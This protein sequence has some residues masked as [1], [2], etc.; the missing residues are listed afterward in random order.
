M[1]AENRANFR[2]LVRP[3]PSTAERNPALNPG[4]LS[5]NE[6]PAFKQLSRL[7]QDF[8]KEEIRVGEFTDKQLSD[9]NFIHKA[10]KEAE[11]DETASHEHGHATVAKKLGWGVEVIS[12]IREGNIL[13][14]TR[15]SPDPT[16][17]ALQLMLDGIAIALGGMASEEMM[18]ITDHRGAGSD[19]RKA[20]ELAKRASLIQFGNEEAAASILEQQYIVAWS[21]VN[22]IG[23]IETRGRNRLLR[24]DGVRT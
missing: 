24:K 14:F 3:Q 6:H 10:N 16:K 8:I 18:G 21:A 17:S 11:R 23:P 19:V 7:R 5:P 22:D 20:K 4:I 1:N 2:V 12:I 15:I 9:F 13:G